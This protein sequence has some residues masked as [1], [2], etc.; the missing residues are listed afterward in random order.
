MATRL[1]LQTK[2][3]SILGSENVYFQPP[4]NIRMAYP[5]IV[6]NRDYQNTR[7]GDN[8]PYSRTLR[9]QVTL[10]D[11]NPD[12]EFLKGIAQM[13][14]STFVRHFTT[15]NLNHDVYDVYF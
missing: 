13:P 3:E 9:Y 15:D 5:A 2:L 10:I 8:Q 7:F 12:S 11:Q 6:Y 14:M 1:D 4:A